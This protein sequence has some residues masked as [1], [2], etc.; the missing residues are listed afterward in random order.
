MIN[1]LRDLMK[2][3]N[4]DAV[5]IPTADPHLSEYIPE[6]YKLREYI[7]GF[8]GSA[9]ELV[10]TM[11]KSGLWTDGRYYIQAEK[12]LSGSGIE[13]F[14]A[15]EKDTPKIHE[16]L[17]KELKKGSVVGVDGSLFSKK[18]LDKI[19]TEI[20]KKKINIDTSFDGFP[21]W[22][23]R[24]PMP[25]DKL[26]LLPEKYS[27]ET[28]SDKVEKVRLHMKED[29]FTHYLTSAPD[30]VMWLLN[31]RGNDVHCTPVALSYLLISKNSINLYIDKN[32]AEDILSY[33]SENGVTVC[34]YNSVYTDLETLDVS[35]YLAVDFD[36]SNYNIIKSI[37]CLHKD[38]K[39]FV[40]YLKCIKNSTEIE[41]V[42]KAYI[43][44][45]TALVKS[46][47]EIYNRDNLTEYD[48]VNIIEKNRQNLDGYYSPSFD[49]I[50]AFG[51][52]AAMVH[53]SPDEK[54]SGK[55]GENGLLLIDTGGQY[56]EG[57][58]DTTRTLVLGDITE[59]ESESLT[60]VLKG[61]I[62]LATAVFPVGKTG[63]DLDGIVR[64]T[65]WKKGLDY[66]HGTG[67]G[68]GYFLSVH[69]GPQR[70][71]P[72]CNEILKE[73]MFLSDEPGIYVENGYGIRIE[74]HL[75]V[76]KYNDEFLCFEVLNYCPIGTKGIKTELLDA[77]EI[78]WL[79]DYNEKCREL[80]I[81]HLTKEEAE[82]LK[83][84]A[85]KI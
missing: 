5:I 48:V 37:K 78:K 84:Y 43:K 33:L 57:T 26:F 10:V 34:D 82:W 21:V 47:Y 23:K 63:R 59:E 52:N 60:L 6:C 85:A 45:N 41:N 72:V 66:N 64:S 38:R 11:D 7:S 44:E 17:C 16:F 54:N 58:T 68:I 50:A 13:L 27:G 35:C 83:T 80:L 65:L 70:I 75:C 69:E 53:Y 20:E 19:I 36:I 14:R 31:V 74:N 56:F 22:K 46:F 67:H 51:E 8:T 73:N 25:A 42:R 61:N 32:K 71:S 81:D 30:S 29:G 9:G 55:V 40:G 49:T 77:E 3:S 4:I 28:L 79:N 12:E 2:K 18:R 39:D 24:P 15:S 62:S 76:K 1:A